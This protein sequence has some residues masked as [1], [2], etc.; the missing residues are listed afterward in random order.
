MVNHFYREGSLIPPLP[1]PDMDFPIVQYA[2]DTLL[3][4][5]A[6]EAQ[7]LLLKSLLADFGRATGLH[8]NYAKS[9]IMPI[10][11]SADRLHALADTFGC[12]VGSL[13]FAYLGLPLGTTRPTMHDLTPLMSQIE[14]R[15]NAS[16]RFPGYG[17]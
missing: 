17:G 9:C 11:I 4:M 7:L 15:L 12:S 14:R 13:P 1:I 16:A 5:Q 3:I 2:D 6:S 8:V 10:N